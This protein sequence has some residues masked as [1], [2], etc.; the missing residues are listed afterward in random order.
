MT[1]VLRTQHA[2]GSIVVCGF[3]KMVTIGIEPSNEWRQ[4]IHIT[5]FPKDDGRNSVIIGFYTKGVI[6]PQVISHHDKLDTWVDYYVAAYMND[7][8]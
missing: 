2:R 6:K 4:R 1:Q 5:V 3:D 7:V 8:K